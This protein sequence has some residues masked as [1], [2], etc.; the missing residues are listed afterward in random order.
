MFPPN[1][2]QADAPTLAP[3]ENLI[4]RMSAQEFEQ[5]VL[6]PENIDQTYELL[7]GRIYLV[8]ANGRSSIIAFKFGTFISMFVIQND[9][10]QCTGADGGYF[11]GNDRLIPDVGF[12]KKERATGEMHEGYFVYAPDLAVEVISPTDR[13]KKIRQKVA[14]Y[15]N[16]GVTVWLVDPKEKTV[17]IYAPQ[18][19]FIELSESDTLDGGDVLPGFTLEV[20]KLFE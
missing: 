9:L 8:V 12:T 14:S 18:K 5:F 10:G 1:T 16:A 3:E 7:N 4:S 2:L 13:D 15:L 19:P 11:I 6:L 17:E 20:K